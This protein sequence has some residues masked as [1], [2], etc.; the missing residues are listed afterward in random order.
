MSGELR[1]PPNGIINKKCE[2]GIPLGLR[3][4]CKD[5]RLMDCEREI[6]TLQEK[7][8]IAVEALDTC[9][10]TIVTK[11][12]IDWKKMCRLHVD[13]ATNALARIL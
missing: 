10:T 7:L 4:Y 13:A 5:C 9:R 8:E 11:D 3:E 12:G 1:P 2:H 6:D